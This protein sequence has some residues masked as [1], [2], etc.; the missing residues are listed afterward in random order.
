M[1]RFATGFKSLFG[2]FEAA[3]AAGAAAAA[4]AGA[5]ALAAIL[6]AAALFAAANWIGWTAAARIAAFGGAALLSGLPLLSMQRLPAGSLRRDAAASVHGLFLGLLLAVM[7]QTWQSGAGAETLCLAWALLLLPW[8]AAVRGPIVF[9]LWFAAASAGFALQGFAPQGIHAD[10]RLLDELLPAVLLAAVFAAALPL[11]AAFRR[12]RQPGAGRRLRSAAALPELLFLSLASA[13]P[14]GSLATFGFSGASPLLPIYALI[15]ITGAAAQ[16]ASRTPEGAAA[17]SVGAA[18]WLCGLAFALIESSAAVL[19]GALILTADLVIAGALSAR[20]ARA[21]AAAD[22][23]PAPAAAS[24]IPKAAAALAGAGLVLLILVL[25]FSVWELSAGAAAMI[26]TAAGLAAEGVRRLRTDRAR[27]ATSTAAAPCPPLAS[28]W[29]LFARLF[30]AAGFVFSL[31]YF[32][33]AGLQGTALRAAALGIVLAALLRSRLALLAGFLAAAAFD[34][35]IFPG[36]AQAAAVLAA[37][38]SIALLSR[39]PSRRRR[40]SLALTPLLAFLWL[41]SLS[42]EPDS[43][44]RFLGWSAN[45]GAAAWWALGAAL[46]AAMTAALRRGFSTGFR[47][48]LAA[49]LLL[50][51]ACRLGPWSLSIALALLAAAS[52][53]VGASSEKTPGIRR[54]CEARRLLAQAMALGLAGCACRYALAPSAGGINLLATAALDQALIALL[55]AGIAVFLAAPAWPGFVKR[56]PALPSPSAEDPAEVSTEE[57]AS[58]PAAPRRA[59][60]PW[61]NA[62]L[63]AASIL[64]AVLFC[65]WRIAAGEAVL[66]EGRP[67]E[68]ALSSVDPRDILM[69]DYAALRYDLGLAPAQ[70]QAA[71]AAAL[72]AGAHPARLRAC[73]AEDNGRLVMTAAADPKSG[74]AEL[75]CPAGT[76]AAVPL[77]AGEPQLPR[78]YFFPSGSA[79]R[80][81]HARFA[82]LRCAESSC[83][84]EALLDE[85]RRPIRP[86]PWE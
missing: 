50:A 47:V 64:F 31:F 55:L 48:V 37:A 58:S 84:L 24:L 46:A 71:C 60:G 34:P 45:W 86:A 63:A 67:L 14:A 32:A 3:P 57:P 27:P 7:G 16:L 41:A 10:G 51:L 39:C 59:A 52:A 15:F 23:R 19:P 83:L 22:G 20:L 11:A 74:V 54:G 69:G 2:R 40:A 9:T 66:S 4:G 73:L 1:T 70:M 72:Q 68:A 18:L 6:A 43:P 53:A 21:E 13:L 82:R 33:D 12:R 42:A 79:E 62:A 85:D 29:G 56:T 26:A 49:A 8:L 78:R 61:I 36:L 81:E 75:A 77:K 17:A 5:A 44:L 65:G 30:C 76:V 80:F 35:S 25:A 38:A 28:A